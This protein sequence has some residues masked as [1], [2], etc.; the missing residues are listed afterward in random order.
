[1]VKMSRLP[2]SVLIVL[3]VALST[4]GT[5]GYAMVDSRHIDMMLCSLNWYA[6]EVVLNKPGIEVNITKLEELMESIGAVQVDKD[7]EGFARKAWMFRYPL[8]KD[9]WVYVQIEFQPLSCSENASRYLAIRVQDRVVFVN[10]TY[11]Y[12]HLSES[13]DKVVDIK[14]AT[15][16]LKKLGFVSTDGSELSYLCR[17]SKE[18]GKMCS[19]EGVKIVGNLRVRVS[20]STYEMKD[21][22]RSTRVLIVVNTT[23]VPKEVIELAREVLRNVLGIDKEP[24]FES[25]V[26]TEVGCRGIHDESTLKK[27]LK[28]ILSMLR[29]NGVIK[30]S[31]EDIDAILAFAK[32]GDAGWEHRIVYSVKEKRWCR[33]IDA[34]SEFPGACLIRVIGIASPEQIAKLDRLPVILTSVGSGKTTTST[35]SA[36]STAGLERVGYEEYSKNV[37]ALVIALAIAIVVGLAVYI[38]TRRL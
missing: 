11:G 17:V 31:E 6:I 9:D 20:V 24:K 27:V 10:K 5:I 15:E 18:K 29:K 16:K 14:E 26:Y 25:E 23:K 33:Y 19:V 36:T 21:G 2:V 7:M 28:D 13:I 34:M 37:E 8:A 3:S 30:I 32:L 38:A 22:Y 1:M 35:A 4:V 12:S